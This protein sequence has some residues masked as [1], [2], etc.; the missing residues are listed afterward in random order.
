MA[1]KQLELG[2]RVKLQPGLLAYIS[3]HCVE[4]SSLVILSSDTGSST[5]DLSSNPI[6]DSIIS[7]GLKYAKYAQ[8]LGAI[9]Y[10]T[11]SDEAKVFESICQQW[12]STPPSDLFSVVQ[13][14]ISKLRDIV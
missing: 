2:V 14:S 11:Q 1:E 13:E 9:A 10:G 12:N 8:E 6:N 7:R 4:A 3:L 5:E